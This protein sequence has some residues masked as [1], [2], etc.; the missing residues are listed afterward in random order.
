MKGK[1]PSRAAFKLTGAVADFNLADRIRGRVCLDLGAAHGGFSRVLLENGARRVYA[2]DVA[3]GIFDYSLRMDKRVVV[4]ERRNVRRIAH[5]WFEE[6][7]F[8]EPW[9][10]TC[11][12]SFRGRERPVFR[13]GLSCETAVRGLQGDEKRCSGG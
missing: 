8:R 4:L 5:D 12:L 13:R 9:F 6:G 2:L 11:D 3:Y 1:Y 7:D 10:V